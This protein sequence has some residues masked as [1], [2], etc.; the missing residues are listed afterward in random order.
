MNSTINRVQISI[1][2]SC[3][4]TKPCNYH[5]IYTHCLPLDVINLLV[6]LTKN[7]D[8]PELNLFTGHKARAFVTWK[9]GFKRIYT[10]LLVAFN[11]H[12]G[13]LS[14]RKFVTALQLRHGHI[15]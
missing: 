3:P 14:R 13:V 8:T 4:I 1:F 11:E 2:F 5:R 7:S 15:S 10:K 9:K 12:H 6:P